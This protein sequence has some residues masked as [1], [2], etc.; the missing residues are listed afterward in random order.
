MNRHHRNVPIDADKARISVLLASFLAGGGARSEE[1]ADPKAAGPEFAGHESASHESASQKLPSFVP[2]RWFRVASAVRFAMA[3]L[4]MSCIG[5]GAQTAHSIG[6]ATAFGFGF[7]N[8]HGI[9]MDPAGDLYVADYGSGHVY[10]EALQ[11]D[12]SY[13]QTV[14]FPGAGAG[15]A[16]GLARDT[17][18][19]FYIAGNGVVTKQTAGAGGGYTESTLGHFNNPVGVAVDLAGDVFVVDDNERSLYELAAGSYAQTTIDAATLP[20]PFAV[21][22]DALGN[23]YV[24]TVR[25]TYIEKYTLNNGVYTKSDVLN[26]PATYGVIADE[27]GNLLYASPSQF[28]KAT[29]SNGTYTEQVYSPYR[30]QALTQG[31][32]RV[33][34]AVS[35]FESTGIR[36]N[37]APSFGSVPVGTPAARQITIGFTVDTAGRFGTPA[38]LTQGTGGLDFSLVTTTCSGVLEAQAGCTVTV[39]FD[40]TVPGLRSGGVALVDVNGN[41]VATATVSGVGVAAQG[42]IY[43]GTQGTLARGLGTGAVATDA[44]G[45]VYVGGSNAGGAND[46]ILKEMPANGGYTQAA[47]GSDIGRIAALAVDGLG[48]LFIADSAKGQ[49]LEEVF[50]PATGTYTQTTA[51]TARGN[52][53]N[54][55]GAVAV[56]GSGTLYLASGSRLL[57]E[58]PYSNGYIQS[59]V[60]PGFANLT[61]LTVDGMGDIFAADA[62]TG[63]VYKETP[64]GG[65]AYTQTTVVDHLGGV[66]GL[67]LD[68]GGTLYI[69]APGTSDGVL[70][71]AVTGT[72]LYTPLSVIPGSVGPGGVAVDGAGN[73]YVTSTQNGVNDL[74]KLDVADLETLTF[75][76]TA[77]GKTSVAQTVTLTNIGNAALTRSGTGTSSANFSV[78]S[79]TTT[80]T[81]SGSLAVA[82][83][84]SLGVA[85]TPQMA[86]P[87]SGTLNIFDNT[88]NKNLLDLPG[89]TQTVRLAAAGTGPVSVAVSD[90]SIVYG[91]AST[92][93]TAA[94]SF[95]GTV[96]PSG[97]LTFVVGNG[98]AVNAVCKAAGSVSTCIATYP[99]GTFAVGAQS[100]TAVQAPDTFYSAGTGTGTLTV[101]AAAVPDFAFTNS[102]PTTATISAGGSTSFSFEVTPLGSG[103]PGQ[104]T[105]AVS[106]LP[107]QATYTLTPSTVG[108]SSGQ[109]TVRLTIQTPAPKTTKAMNMPQ[110]SPWGKGVAA[111]TAM[112]LPFGLKRRGRIRLGRVLHLVLLAVISVTAVAGLSG[113]GFSGVFYGAPASYTITVTASSGSLQHSAAAS[114]TVQ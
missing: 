68:A 51:F 82:A 91:T 42:V 47:L 22:I 76:S 44:G 67:G 50:Q 64:G 8:P 16:I 105:F 97:G 53:Q 102:G 85:F 72:G 69:T 40:P 111:L 83:S 20:T 5:A 15:S 65:G 81:A 88:L 12:G 94:I 35:Y 112:L 27:L 95:I 33:I 19:N 24:G 13:T 104:V 26:A 48:N 43:P 100:I 60:N 14:L 79:A 2:A 113:C 63:S 78:D 106:G 99:S 54:P 62:G 103:F 59:I 101:T 86:G 7:N 87:L 77:V 32:D 61:A 114:L 109:Q 31:P 71:Y 66:N 38:V 6:E 73:L 21:S 96:A 74:L 46:S 110:A 49:V 93:L 75:A 4:L 10:R 23:L 45:N 30:V 55:V 41:V 56:D 107:P 37:T 28:M 1:L 39:A 3:W 11:A 34:Y 89:A 36:L 57:K 90:L 52:G 80:C 92:T 29:F 17:D 98:T 9:I 58:V 108:V 70:R 84:C 25:G 18:G